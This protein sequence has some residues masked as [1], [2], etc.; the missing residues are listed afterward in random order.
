MHAGRH[1]AVARGPPPWV[2]ASAVWRWCPWVLL[3]A[4]MCTLSN[5]ESIWV[6]VER[7]GLCHNGA[8]LSAE[9][10]AGPVCSPGV[11]LVLE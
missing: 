6:L 3:P 10:A 11:E 2:S 9:R 8:V 5:Q 4:C 7:D 1:G